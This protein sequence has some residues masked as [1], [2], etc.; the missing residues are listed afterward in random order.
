MYLLARIATGREERKLI[1][2]DGEWKGEVKEG[3]EDSEEKVNKIKYIVR[4][5]SNC[6][7]KQKAI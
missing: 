3:M 2:A 6:T 5:A 4:I 7:Q 1:V